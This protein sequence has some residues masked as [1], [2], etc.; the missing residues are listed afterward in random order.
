LVVKPDDKTDEL[1]LA[2][3]FYRQDKF[4]E[5]ARLQRKVGNEGRAR[6]L[7][8]FRDQKPY[9]LS[10][11]DSAHLKFI[12]LDPL[13]LVN[14]SVNG[15]DQVC[16]LIDTGGAEVVL[17][18]EF[19]KRI[20]AAQFGNETGIFA[21][22]K[23][24]NYQ[25]GRVDSIRLGNLTVKNVPLEVLDTRRFDAIA[26][27]RK[28]EGIIGTVLLYH[29][30]STLDYGRGE[31]VLAPKAKRGIAPNHIEEPASEV[32][33]W[34]AGDHFMVAWGR[35]N[36]TSVQLLFIDTGLAGMGFTAP[37]ST[38]K[39]AGITIGS[40]YTEGIGGGGRTKAFPI[41]IDEIALG[42]VIAKNILG[43]AGVFPTSLENKFGFR[44]GG[45]LSHSFFK[46]YA[47]TID[48]QR[49]KYVLRHS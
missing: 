20:G 35:I 16:F 4:Q 25:L 27:G 13:P 26:N 11:R 44:V 40:N 7:E 14:V 28:V 39:E 33:F 23:T 47:V 41:K 6:M 37:E 46:N 19:A 18:T 15:S 9:Q 2:E 21:G 34:M 24:S 49:M 29:F 22:G 1:L 48:F 36:K 43:V 31:L 12:Q 38:L 42:D 10:S 5:A 30:L 8:S 32:P 17:D 45:L 3:A